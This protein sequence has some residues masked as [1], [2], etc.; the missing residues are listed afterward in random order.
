GPADRGS[1]KKLRRSGP[2]GAAMQKVAKCGF[3]F[4]AEDGIRDFH[5]TGVQT[6]ALPISTMRSRAP[7]IP[8]GDS[9]SHVP[10]PFRLYSYSPIFSR[11]ACSNIISHFESGALMSVLIIGHSSGDGRQ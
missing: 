3:F 8:P 9:T 11:S 1:E 7:N 4:Q 2:G 5:V 6:C 10:S